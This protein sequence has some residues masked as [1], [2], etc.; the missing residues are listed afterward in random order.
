MKQMLDTGY[1]QLLH[2]QPK[3]EHEKDAYIHELQSAVKELLAEVKNLDEFVALLRKKQFGSSSEQTKPQEE[4]LPLGMFPEAEMEYKEQVPEPFKADKRG[5][6]KRNER[7]Q[8]KLVNKDDIKDIF[9][10]IPAERCFCQCGAPLVEIGKEKTREVFERVPAKL[11]L[12]RHWKVSYTCPECK[13]KGIVRIVSRPVPKPLLNHSM[14]GATVVAEV[15]N[16]K[17]VNAVP[18]YRQEEIWKSLGVSFSR[19]TMANW[20]IRCAE[21]WLA[22]LWD[23]LR[24]ELLKREVLHADETVVQVLK[25][26]GK[27]AQ[28]KSYMW[29]YRTGNDGLPPIVLFEYQPGR[30]GEY[31]KRFLEGFRWYLHTDGYAGYNQVPGITRCGCWAHLRRKFVEAIP[32]AKAN[33]LGLT[34]PAEIGRN[35][36]DQLFHAEKILSALPAEERQQKRL[37]VEEPLLRAFWCWLD[38]MSS[39]TLAGSLKKAVQYAQNQRPYMEN[40]LKDAR[41]QISNNLAENAIRPFTVGRKNWLF[42][43][44]VKGAKASAVI[45]SIVETAKANRLNAQDYLEMLLDNLPDMDIHAHP[46]ELEKVFPWGEYTNEFFESDE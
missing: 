32:D 39:Q 35:Y 18:L 14:A 12:H 9:W 7:E 15:M 8:W 30:S 42:S 16:Q 10:R 37:E 6:H 31:P 19:T 33:P 22:P 3:T 29:V 23:A 27:T 17:Y 1:E 25:E 40:Y 21:D 20:V 46:E 38:E 24:K 4:A 2:T 45:Y 44:T 41:C 13:K 5:V 43:D 28:S 11:E 26:D 36:C 34:T